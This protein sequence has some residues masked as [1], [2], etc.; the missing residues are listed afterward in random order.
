MSE[1]KDARPIFSTRDFDTLR[2]ALV[3]YIRRHDGEEGIANFVNLHHR[4]GR[5]RR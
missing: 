3:E 5:I 1:L 4:L 2:T